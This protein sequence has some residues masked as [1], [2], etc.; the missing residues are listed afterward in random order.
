M[1]I[2]KDASIPVGWTLHANHFVP[3]QYV[4]VRGRSTGKGFAGGMKRHNFHGQGA[5]H[6]VSL[7]HRS[8]GSTGMHSKPGRVFKNT[9][10]PGHLGCTTTYVRNLRIF[11]IDLERNL[12]YIIGSVP[13]KPGTVLQIRD[14]YYFPLYQT[15][16]A[17]TTATFDGDTVAFE[18]KTTITFVPP[19]RKQKLYPTNPPFPTFI[20][21]LMQYESFTQPTEPL[22]SIPKKFL[23]P[24]PFTGGSV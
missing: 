2:T 16:E 7:T 20:D 5:S 21:R 22:Y 24:N 8:I 23:G 6:G 4:D 12:L 15:S 18:P 14:A 17:V 11:R 9:K 10:M 19:Q 1:K 13:G 3:G